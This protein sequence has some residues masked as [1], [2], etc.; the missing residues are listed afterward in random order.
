MRSGFSVQGRGRDAKFPPPDS[1]IAPR[2]AERIGEPKLDR[3]PFHFIRLMAAADDMYQVSRLAT[4]MV[5]RVCVLVDI[6]PARRVGSTRPAF[7]TTSMCGARHSLELVGVCV[8]RGGASLPLQLLDLDARGGYARLAVAFGERSSNR[9]CRE[10]SAH[11]RRPMATR[12]HPAVRRNSCRVSVEQFAALKDAGA[13]YRARSSLLSI[14]SWCGFPYCVFF[15][16]CC[17]IVRR[18]HV[19]VV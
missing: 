17:F 1:V 9:T 6:A 15:F 8:D 5:V 10:E 2:A 3:R 18:Y 14:S 12:G 13:C 4:V 7:I 16:C 11:D 19:G